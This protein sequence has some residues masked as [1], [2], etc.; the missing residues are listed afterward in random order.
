MSVLAIACSIV[1]FVLLILCLM[2]LPWE[3]IKNKAKI[4]RQVLSKSEMK[5]EIK[6]KDSIQKEKHLVVDKACT[7]SS[8]ATSEG[9]MLT[10]FKIAIKQNKKYSKQTKLKRGTTIPLETL[11]ASVKIPK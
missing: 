1:C 5:E 11:N 2:D 4:I 3:A 7:S 9:E 6:F 8:M 10:K